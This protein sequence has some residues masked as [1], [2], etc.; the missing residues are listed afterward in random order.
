ME[1]VVAERE[2]DDGAVVVVLAAGGSGRQLEVADGAVLSG[3]GLK[4]IWF[5]PLDSNFDYKYLT[6]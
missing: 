4:V 3:L 2:A 1:F 6:Y 5:I